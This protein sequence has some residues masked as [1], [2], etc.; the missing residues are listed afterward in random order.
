G[1]VKALKILKDVKGISFVQF[2]SMDVV[3]HP[4]VQ[5]NIERY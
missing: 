2:T 3:R 5:I 1:L 4:V